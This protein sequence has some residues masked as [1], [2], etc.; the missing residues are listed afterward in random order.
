V[1]LLEVTMEHFRCYEPSANVKFPPNSSKP[2]ITFVG[3]GGSGK[4]S[5]FLAIIW[6]LYG[7]R[8]LEAYADGRPY[9]RQAPRTDFDLMNMDMVEASPRPSMRV[10]LVFEHNLKKY[11]LHRT[12]AAKSSHP[13]SN[14]DL[15]A[16][17]F[18]LTE[19]GKREPEKYP[20]GVIDDILPFGA[21][22]FFFFDGEDIRRYS[23]SKPK[24]TKDAIELVLGIPEIREARND[25]LTVQRRLLDQ[26]KDDETLSETIRD[27][28]EKLS[29]AISKTEEFSKT[30]EQ[31]KR[32]LA[33]TNEEI[34]QAEIRRGELKEIAEENEKLGGINAEKDAVDHSIE[35]YKLRRQ[36]L[37]EEIPYYLIA[38]QVRE[39]LERFKKLAGTEDLGLQISSVEA[40]L[41][42]L[43]ELLAANTGKCLCGTD[44]DEMHKRH[45]VVS[46]K[47]LER[48][49]EE[50]REKAAKKT[51]PPIEEIQYALGRLE[52]IHVDYKEVDKIINDLR[53]QSVELDDEKLSIEGK[54]KRSDVQEA[55]KVQGFLDAL[56]KR[57][58]SLETE[59]RILED[60]YA[61]SL[62]DKNRL[63]GTLRKQNYQKGSMTV[64]STRQEAA[65]RMANAFNMVIEELT[66]EKKKLIVQNASRFFEHIGKEGGW[67]GISIEEDY[68]TWMLDRKGRPVPPSEGYRELVALSLIYGLN[69]AASYK[70][71]VIM[72]FVLGRLDKARQLEVVNNLSDFADQVLILLLDSEI[73]SDDVRRKLDS[74]SAA[75][76]SIERDKSTGSSDF[77]KSER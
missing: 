44:L 37:V 27:N 60:S 50:L 12:V 70:A 51:T 35:E 69:K 62:E 53:V 36:S 6:A 22:Q 7:E 40:R 19:F 14:R 31:K 11:T 20:E 71:P 5:L 21:S 2:V 26:M 38:P 10:S 15:G 52:S 33:Q 8:A 74:L 57:K 55:V 34:I 47:A 43:D 1:R 63:E 72:D 42:V 25:L 13:R 54:I 18:K 28:M 30:I 56:N 65:A 58:G 66:T 64:T 24:D 59:V 32:E 17:D 67:Q 49:L 61:T 48:S 76:L 77:R 4:T 68:S 45:I 73:Q 29:I 16:E 39:T 46:R 23:G 3:E 41:G 75:V 9:D